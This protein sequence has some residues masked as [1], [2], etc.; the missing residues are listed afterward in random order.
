MGRTACTHKFI[1]L[2]GFNWLKTLLLWISIYTY[3]LVCNLYVRIFIWWRYSNKDVLLLYFNSGIFSKYDHKADTSGKIF[4]LS[5]TLWMSL[6][7][8]ITSYVMSVTC[9]K[10]LSLVSI[11]ALY[12]DCLYNYRDVR[13]QKLY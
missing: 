12:T 5:S 6:I 11:Y 7:M 10:F 1:F 13:T 3:I 4:F 2:C 9:Y 8:L